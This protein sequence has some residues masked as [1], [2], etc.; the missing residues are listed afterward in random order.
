M[1]FS[2]Y[3]GL[4]RLSLLFSDGLALLSPVSRSSILALRPGSKNLEPDAL[5]RQ[6]GS[7]EGSPTTENILPQRC[8]VGAASW[9]V[10]QAV[11]RALLLVTRP[12]RAPKRECYSSLRS[13]VPLSFTGVTLPN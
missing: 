11:R 9:G 5:S 1:S 6:F 2:L 10:E 8:V 3:P 12:A 7:S 13:F 4:V